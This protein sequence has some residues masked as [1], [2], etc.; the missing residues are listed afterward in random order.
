M[1]WCAAQ[2]SPR[3]VSESRPVPPGRLLQSVQLNIMAFCKEFNARTQKYK[4]D[5]PMAVKL[6]AYKDN[7]FEF[8]V[9]SP[10]VTWFLKKAAGI[11]SGSCWPGH[12]S[13]TEISLRHVYEIAKI[14]QADPFKSHLSIEAICKSIIGTANSMGIEVVKDL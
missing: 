1:W 14:K 6:T 2:S 11:E 13:V 12:V 9:K 7:T 8:T 3:S 5:T 4:P 10:S